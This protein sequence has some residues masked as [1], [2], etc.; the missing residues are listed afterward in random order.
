MLLEWLKSFGTNILRG[1]IV[2]QLC[3]GRLESF[4]TN[5]LR[6][7]IVHQLCAG[8]N[9]KTKADEEFH[10]VFSNHIVFFLFFLGGGGRRSFAAS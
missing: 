7:P 8:R 4:G 6:G 5:I 10:I 1:P 3:A 2:H 9:I